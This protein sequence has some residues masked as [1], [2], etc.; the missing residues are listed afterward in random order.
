MQLTP[1]SAGLWCEGVIISKEQSLFCS[2]F[3]KMKREAGYLCSHYL[4]MHETSPE[5]T[6]H[7]S[8]LQH[9]LSICYR[10]KSSFQPLEEKIG[11]PV[12]LPNR[13]ALFKNQIDH[14]D[15]FF[16]CP[17]NRRELVNF[18][19]RGKRHRAQ[20]Y[21]PPALLPPPH[22]PK[23]EPV[24]QIDFVLL[25]GCVISRGKIMSIVSLMDGECIMGHTFEMNYA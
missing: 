13:Q 1:L 4:M 10:S 12:Y 11:V 22:W 3:W 19:D 16:F 2:F 24:T 18:K 8:W 6:Q 23:Q 17:P 9:F 5:E 14:L 20:Q 15:F 21:L 25:W 7:L